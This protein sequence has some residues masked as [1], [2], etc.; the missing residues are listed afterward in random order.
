MKLKICG[1]NY[2]IKRANIGDN[3]GLCE[4]AVGVISIDKELEKNTNIPAD[5]VE[6]HEILHAILFETGLTSLFP[7]TT[8]EAVVSGLATQLW[9]VGYRRT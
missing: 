1:R 5:L 6:L 9:A 2:T 3:M 4:P 8:E 7:E